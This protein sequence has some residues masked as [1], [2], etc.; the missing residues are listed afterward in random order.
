MLYILK[1]ILIYQLV[2][3][4]TFQNLNDNEKQESLEFDVEDEHLKKSPTSSEAD[5]DWRKLLKY[6]I[7]KKN[8]FMTEN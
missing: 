1:I 5:T 3:K 4:M 8:F 7:K 6:V 2:E